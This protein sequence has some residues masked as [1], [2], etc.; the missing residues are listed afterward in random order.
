[1]T[2]VFPAHPGESRDPA[3]ASARLQSGRTCDQIWVPTFAGMSGG[4]ILE[5][6][7][8]ADDGG[9]V[10]RGA[11]FFA[12]ARQGVSGK[13]RGPGLQRGRRRGGPRSA[14]DLF[15]NEASSI[16]P[17]LTSKNKF[18]R[19]SFALRLSSLA[20]AIGI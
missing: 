19:F 5:N 6:V 3:R 7:S 20:G 11:V 18:D 15:I 13:A 14:R 17:S 1:M 12:F 2:N 16:F 9:V 10:V 4:K 8:A